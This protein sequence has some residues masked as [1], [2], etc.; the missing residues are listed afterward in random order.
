MDGECSS[1]YSV[2]LPHCSDNDECVANSYRASPYPP[3][4]PRFFLTPPPIAITKSITAIM[5]DLFRIFSGSSTFF[6][7]DTLYDRKKRYLFF[8]F[9]TLYELKVFFF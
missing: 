2:F 4:T 5:F 8:F 3:R 9:F 7:V 1:V 6:T